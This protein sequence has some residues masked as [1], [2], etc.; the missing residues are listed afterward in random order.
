LFNYYITALTNVVTGESEP[1]DLASVKDVFEIWSGLM[2]RESRRS[3][4]AA[5]ESTG[6]ETPE[7][8]RTHKGD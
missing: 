8:A 5:K 2:K 1:L 3:R 6:F 7:I 4:R